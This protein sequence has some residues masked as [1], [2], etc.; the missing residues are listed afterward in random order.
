MASIYKRGNT[1]TVSVSVPFEG[2]YKKKTKSGF[3][4]KTEAN[5]WA[6]KTEGAKIDGDINFN[7]SKPLVDF[8]QEWVDTYKVDVSRST[9]DGYKQTIRY[10]TEY[11][12]KTPLEKVT[13]QKA[14][15]F[16]NDMATRHMLSTVTIT[17]NRIKTALEDALLDGIIKQNPFARTKSIGKP[18]HDKSIKFLELNDFENLINYLKQ[19]NSL[20]T[21]ALL[22]TALTGARI[23]EVL[24]LTKDDIESGI[25]H[26]N[27][28]RDQSKGTIN[29]PK[30]PNSIRDVDVPTWLSD[31]LLQTNSTDFIFDFSQPTLNKV[32]AKSLTE[33]NSAKII[34]LHGL[35]HSHASYLITNDVAI[36]YISERLSH[37]NIGI[38]QN[39][40]LHLL[41]VKRDREI[42]KVTALF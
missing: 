28:S 13:R 5:Q 17:R 23:G 30:T 39:T 40:Y 15:E 27:K 41:K 37:S 38:T 19:Q 21:N 14:Q 36:E 7:P 33:I 32:L 25:I 11:F 8:L 42:K 9:R 4:T 20:E 26:I 3:K 22:T 35:R 6:I 29:V 16:V 12:G 2:S 1:W 31:R 34:T 24:A 18:I 10:A